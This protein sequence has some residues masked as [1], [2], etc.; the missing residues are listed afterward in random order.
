MKFFI[1]VITLILC[2]FGAVAAPDG[3]TQK[4]PPPLDASNRDSSVKPGEDFFLFANGNWIKKTEIPPEYSRWGAFNELI[5]RNNDALHNIAEKASQTHVDPKL[6]PE[7]QK[8][9]DYYAS[10]MD[11]KAVEKARTIP[12]AQEFQKIDAI[13]DHQ[14]VQKEIAHLHSMG[15]NPFFNFGSGQD[16]KDSTHDIAQAVQGGLGMPDRDYYTKQDADM[17]Q[18]REKYVAHVT[19]M[20][21]LLGEPADKASQDAKKIMALETKLAEASRTRVELR[22]P[23]KNYNKMGVRQLQDLTPDWNWSD[24]FNSIN[25]LEPRDVNVHQ[26]DFFKAADNLFKST[27][28]DD[29]K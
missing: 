11:E 21:S 7:T 19:K 1:T 22:D 5:E 8:V 2:S 14:D 15:I 17:Q 12:L 23:I 25:L 18:K 26:P 29:W 20:L 6:A 24:Y 13:K 27:S 10:G 4:D 28:L 16:A 3:Q 9:G